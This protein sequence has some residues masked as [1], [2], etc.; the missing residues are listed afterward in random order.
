LTPHD[1]M[2]GYGNYSEENQPLAWVRGY[3]LYAAHLIVAVFVVSMLV[4][5]LLLAVGLGAVLGWLTF[6]STQVWQG[7][8]WRVVT[9]GLVNP[10]TLQ[11]V[12]DM[13]MIVWFGRE[14]EKFFG[15]RIFLQLFASVYL[16][17]PLLFSA[18]GLATTLRL[19]GE[20]GAFALFIA[21]ATLYPNAALLFNILAKWAALVLV[22]ISAL[23]ALANRDLVALLALAAT[24]GTAFLFV[25][26]QQGAFRLPRLRIKRRAPSLRVLPDPAPKQPSAV[27]PARGRE[28]ATMAEVDAL[29]D[30]IAKSGIGSLTARERAKLEAARE[31]LMKRGSGRG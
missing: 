5:T 4:T 30:K 9:Y 22:G 25:R 3:P 31:D 11:F 8:I 26:Y 23:M 24:C 17:T 7:Q 1:L 10:P 29:L 12:I 13:F 19:S 20:T 14:V 15:R 16:V 21:F 2:N 6:T 28:E 27:A 18:L